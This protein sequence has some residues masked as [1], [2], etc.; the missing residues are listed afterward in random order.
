M[1]EPRLDHIVVNARDRMDE[2][3]GL[4]RRLG[5]HLT[6]RGY[7]TLGS[8][9]HLAIFA[10]DYLELIGFAPGERNVRTDIVRFPVGLNAVVYGTEDT[11][12]LH[13]TLVERKVTAQKPVAFSRPVDLGGV[14]Y[15]AHFQTVR[16]GP[17]AMPFGRVYFCRHMTRDLVWRSEWQ[18]HPNGACGIA[19]ATIVASN[20]DSVVTRFS[21][22]FGAE[23]IKVGQKRKRVETGSFNLDII[24]AEELADRFG[25]AAPDAGSRSDYMASL[26]I[27]TRSLDQAEQALKQ[28]GVPTKR[29]DCRLTV[30]A[31]E[32]LDV[33]LQFIER[34]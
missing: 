28:G 9:N 5:F 2:A 15:T 30:P 19:G 1:V 33:T 3:I 16:L 14:T 22:L 31:S 17:D 23:V 10:N 7:H 24:T 29:E 6:E 18:E 20:P 4:Y 26:T 8:I 21:Q 34:I 11:A 13:A 25:N 12:A 32:A 27:L